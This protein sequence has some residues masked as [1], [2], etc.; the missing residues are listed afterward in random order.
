M[1]SVWA[2]QPVFCGE[3]VNRRLTFDLSVVVS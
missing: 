2:M 3:D 1:C